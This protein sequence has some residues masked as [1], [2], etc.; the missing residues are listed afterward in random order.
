MSPTSCTARDRVPCQSHV[1]VQKSQ[2]L[3]PLH[4]LNSQSWAHKFK[5]PQQHR[6][7]SHLST[8]LLPI[9]TTHV[10]SYFKMPYEPITRVGARLRISEARL[11]ELV[12]L[13]W[14]VG[15][16]LGAPEAAGAH[17]HAGDEVAEECQHLYCGEAQHDG[18]LLLEE[19]HDLEGLEQLDDAEGLHGSQQPKLLRIRSRGPVLRAS[20]QPSD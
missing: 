12:Q 18:E 13:L 16:E 7:N 1:S 15:V 11:Q 17:V 6:F 20:L 19:P 10:Q 14:R 5:I 2:P 8:P 9:A 4:K 3:D